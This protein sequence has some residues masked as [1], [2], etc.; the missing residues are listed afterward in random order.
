MGLG[1]DEIGNTCRNDVLILKFGAM[2]FEKYTNTQ[3]EFIHQTMR[4]LARLTIALNRLDK[5][6]S[7]AL[8]DFFTPDKFDLIIQATKEIRMNHISS[9]SITIPEFHSLSL[10][11]KIGYALKICI[12][13]QRGSAIRAGNMKK[14]ES[15][16]SFKEFIEMGWNIRISSNALSTLY[17]R[18]FNSTQL[19][20]IT[21]DLV[22]LSRYIDNN[23]VKT[24]LD[25]ESDNRD[26]QKWS[27]LATLCL[28]RIILFNKRRSGEASKMKMS[29]YISRPSWEE[30]N[31][32]EIRES[33]TPVEKKL[34][35][36]MTM[37][38]V[39]GKRGRKVPIILPPVIKE[40]I[41]ILI[42]HR[43]ECKISFH[44][45]Y[46]FA[47]SNES[48]SF[49]RGHD[50]LKKI[51]EEIHLKNPDAIT[52]T[53]LRKYVATVCQLFNMSE[54]EYDWHAWHLGH[55]ITV[56]REFYRMH[57]SAI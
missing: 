4:Q 24:K 22:K 35:E 8:A 54:N 34:A 25:V 41:D 12:A 9:D 26:N 28:A 50:C 1:S 48:K 56:H 43:D 6:C 45:K 52:G 57:E 20:P 33:L 16:L 27:R 19:L 32:E 15:L 37:V 49:L 5:N 11:L 3:S 2:Q 31:T 18:K 46:V 44:N 30:Q 7:K 42:R 29:D 23:I 55:D 40:C 51:C 38:E 10:A 14:N 39:E 53:K 13:I 21:D 17:R 36:S 47:R